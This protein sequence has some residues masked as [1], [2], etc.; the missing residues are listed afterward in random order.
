MN[1]TFP[2]TGHEFLVMIVP[3]LTLF[4]G[5]GFLVF[6]RTIF[7]FMGLEPR[8]VNPEAI[9]EARSSFSGALLAVSLGCLLLQDP[10]A[11]QPGLNFV[12]AC[13]WTIAAAGR[14]LQMLFDNGL[15]KRVQARFILASGMALAAWWVT[16][17]PAFRCADPLSEFCNFP[18]EFHG[19]VLMAVALLTLGLGLISLFMPDA[20]LSIMRLQTSIKTPFA[21]GETRGTLGGFYCAIGGTYLL[22][23]QP[24]DFVAL[25]MGA[26]WVFTGIG[27]MLSI[28]VDRGWTLYNVFA[29]LFELVI[30]TLVIGLIFGIV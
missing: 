22:L 12:L 16:E 8:P 11:L 26:A 20:A 4:L 28:L 9:A 3:I 14:V 5:L 10:I 7:S 25:V 2:D 21:R 27:R 23:P 24:V 6:P 30:G 15:R 18:S 1:L 29:T 17:V 13:G 19:W